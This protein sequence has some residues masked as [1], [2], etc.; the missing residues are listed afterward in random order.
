MPAPYSPK[1]DTWV[2]LSKGRYK[3]D[4]A[5]V[6]DFDEEQWLATALVVPRLD[7]S[8]KP[9][10]G[11]GKQK[12]KTRHS[13]GL[14]NQRLIKQL[15]GDFLPEEAF[16]TVDE[17][18][19][20][21]LASCISAER[22]HHFRELAE[23]QRLKPGDYVVVADGQSKGCLGTVHSI[24]GNEAVVDLEGE[25]A[26]ETVAL[27]QLRK[28]V[29]VGDHVQIVAGPEAGKYGWVVSISG[30]SLEIYDQDGAKEVIWVAFALTLMLTFRLL[31]LP[32]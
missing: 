21:E 20:F 31:R 25:T 30:Q 4:L 18:S 29:V 19:A 22:M 15:Y 6:W 17:L 8:G 11:K 27:R 28:N 5:Y 13:Q 12:Q 16:P 9:Q 2:H 7:Y 26:Q 32:R 10:K 1:P 14:F 23:A 24:S 3:G